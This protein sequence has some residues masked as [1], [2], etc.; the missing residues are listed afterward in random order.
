MIYILDNNEAYSD[1]TILFVDTQ[2]SLAVMQ[3]VARAL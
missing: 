1:H 3:A 2:Y